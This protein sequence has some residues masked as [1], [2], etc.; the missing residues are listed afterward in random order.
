[1]PCCALSGRNITNKIKSLSHLF[2]IKT[3]YKQTYYFILLLHKKVSLALRR[4]TMHLLP[5]K[6]PILDCLI[7]VGHNQNTYQIAD[8]YSA[9]FN[10]IVR[11]VNGNGRNINLRKPNLYKKIFLFI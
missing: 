1:M 7:E 11:S 2:S 5:F 10:R 8:D 6:P 3:H 4:L 9:L